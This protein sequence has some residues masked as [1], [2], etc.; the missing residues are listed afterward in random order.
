MS[1]I[2]ILNQSTVVRDGD[3]K[4]IAS[5]IDKQLKRH[6]CPAWGAS[7]TWSCSFYSAASS[8][9]ADAYRMWI[10]DNADQ[11]GALGYHDQ[12]PQGKPYA[13]VFAK[14]VLDN[15]GDI[16]KSENSVSVTCSHEA[17]EIFG[18]PQAGYWAQTRDGNLI[19]LELC[20]P[21]EA[22]AYPISIGL[23]SPVQVMVSNFCLPAYF[24]T[25]PD[26]AKYDMLGSL[27]APF[28]MTS[29]GY[30]ILMRAGKVS[31]KFGLLYPGWKRA[32]KTFH[33]ART[34]RR[35]V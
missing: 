21:V 20:D 8:P 7:S 6:A 23:V 13:R 12:D 28:S 24:D 31:Q 30:Q 25:E 5:A 33:A 19:A 1:K 4:L 22:D 18:D 16:M 29:G 2:A 9:P 27:N 15:G 14:T 26:T 11:A 3:C 35:T 10:L 34:A 17:L 32:G